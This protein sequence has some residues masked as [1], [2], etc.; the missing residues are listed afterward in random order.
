MLKPTYILYHEKLG[1][2][3][4]NDH[5]MTAE[6]DHNINRAKQYRMLNSIKDQLRNII[7]GSVHF[8]TGHPI[9]GY[10]IYSISNGDINMYCS[11]TEFVDNIIQELY[12][13]LN[14]KIINDFDNSTEKEVNSWTDRKYKQYKTERRK[15]R[16][17]NIWE[18]I[19]VIDK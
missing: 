11:Q 12:K 19:K 9:T 15:I 14:K 10:V 16:E 8:K 4:G 2:F 6:F 17:I 1:Y 3:K 7:N 18:E 5:I 13:K